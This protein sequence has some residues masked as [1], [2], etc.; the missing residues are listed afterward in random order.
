VLW[1]ATVSKPSWASTSIEGS[2]PSPSADI[3]RKP[4]IV[5]FLARSVPGVQLVSTHTDS[6]SAAAFPSYE[7]ATIEHIEFE[8]EEI[9]VGPSALMGETYWTH[10]GRDHTF[11]FVINGRIAGITYWLD[12]EP[13]GE[14]DADGEPAVLS[15]GWFWTSVACPEKRHRVAQGLEFTLDMTE[16]E[17]AQTEEDVLEVVAKEVLAEGAGE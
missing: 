16:E 12:P 4:G 2:N 5:V 13:R 3:P 1:T 9:R 11:G 6:C 14:R 7:N 17:V 15:P 8:R 10:L